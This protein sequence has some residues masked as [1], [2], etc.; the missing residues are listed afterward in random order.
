MLVNADNKTRLLGVI[1]DPIAQSLS[2]VLHNT[3]SGQSGENFIMLPF[4]VALGGAAAFLEA[5]KRV[6]MRGFCVTMPLKKEIISS[7]D[8]MSRLA[9]EAGAVNCVC[10]GEDG[11]AVGHNTDAPGFVMSL[12]RHI[13]GLSG[14]RAA[15]LGAGGAARAVARGLIDAGAA[16]IVF[17]AR[18]RERA[19]EACALTGEG[20]SFL[21]FSPGELS[22]AAGEA[23]L[24]V[25]C[26]PLGMKGSPDDFEDLSFLNNFSGFLCDIITSPDKT[27]LLAR[28][29]ALG[30]P[31]E[32]G[33]S[34]LICQAM[35]AFELFSGANL[36]REE[37]FNTA[38]AAVKAQKGDIG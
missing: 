4:R 12:S 23:D 26:T 35:L 37:A 18:N 3:F 9:K 22:H 33:L 25:N 27:A 28:A 15:I 6:S 31:C 11:R 36:H 7:L 5:V 38:L 13:G 20:A 21:G 32:N 10:I 29:E 17:L 34:M 19:R 30:I 8:G 16:G 14:L 2:P 24:I 1:G